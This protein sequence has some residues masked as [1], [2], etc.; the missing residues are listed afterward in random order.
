[1]GMHLIHAQVA[2][3]PLP[4]EA[5][6]LAQSDS[7]FTCSSLNTCA[8]YSDYKKVKG[9]SYSVEEQTSTHS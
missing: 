1:M 3:S 2:L 8:S 4:G 6:H 9:R 7:V 5:F